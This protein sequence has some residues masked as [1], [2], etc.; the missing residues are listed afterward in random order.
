M[1]LRTLDTVLRNI[2][3]TFDPYTKHNMQ[4]IVANFNRISNSLVVSSA[5]IQQMLN[6]QNGALAKSLE[7]INSFTGN[8]ARNNEKVT[9][10][11]TNFE[12]TTDKLAKAD[13]DGTVN[14]LRLTVERLNAS[15]EKLDSKDG[16][17]GK[18]LNDTQ[19]YDNLANTTRSLNILMDDIRVNPKR[20]VSISIFGGRSKGQYLTSP[21]PVN[22]TTVAR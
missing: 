16:S 17:I 8:L 22:D 19:V 9:N 18:L 21:L 12:T 3:E 7:N 14:Q 13:I 1:T 5:S 6:Q 10:S 2:N 11:L 15:V 4:D 20:Y